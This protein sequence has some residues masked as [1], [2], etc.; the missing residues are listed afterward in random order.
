MRVSAVL[1]VVCLLV[2][3]GCAGG[4]FGSD[5]GNQGT[6]T[7]TTVEETVNAAFVTGGNRTTVTLEV[8]N[9]AGERERGL[10]YRESLAKNHGMVF[11]FEDPAVQSFWMKNTLIPLDMVFVSENGTV[12]NVAHAD[13]QPN[14]SDS[15][16]RSYQSDGDAK[17]VVEMRQGFADRVGIEPGSKLVFEESRPKVEE[18]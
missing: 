13:T 17:Y 7:P 8:A 18:S 1:S 5:G 2:L 12:L 16:L 9:S 15:E 3:A 10:M 14:A 6:Q 11:V 4:G